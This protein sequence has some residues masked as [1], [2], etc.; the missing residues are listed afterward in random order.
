MS[1]AKTGEISN[2]CQ[3]NALLT[4]REYLDDYA[5]EDTKKKG[6]EAIKRELNHIK[7]PVVR[8]TCEGYL[9]KIDQGERDFRF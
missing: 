1:L 6:M 2:C 4:L 5:S 8:A 7:S 3:P 9:E